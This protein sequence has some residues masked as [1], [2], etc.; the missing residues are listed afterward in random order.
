MS[1]KS[2]V[3]GSGFKVRVQRFRVQ[4]SRKDFNPSTLNGER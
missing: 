4:G 2:S 3:S 1:I